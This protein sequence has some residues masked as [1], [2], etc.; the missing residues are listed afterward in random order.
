[1]SETTTEEEYRIV[2]V[3]KP[4]F[5]TRELIIPVSGSQV[6]SLFGRSQYK[7]NLEEMTQTFSHPKDGSTMNF[8]PA[9]SEEFLPIIAYKFEERAK[10]EIFDPSRLQLGWIL[11]AKE[12]VYI[13]ALD[14]Q[15][16]PIINEKDLES[17]IIADNKVN[18][19]YFFGDASYVPYDSFEQGEQD[20]DTFSRG[21]LARAFENTRDGV[22][23]N[24]K[25]ISSKE[26]YP[27]G[28]DV[29]GFDPVDE[30]IL[31]IATLGSYVGNRLSV[32]GY[33]WSGSY[34]YGYAFGVFDSTEGAAQK[35]GGKK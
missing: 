15:G 9:T 17:F 11:R 35:N 14:E 27:N 34:G 26:H 16:N 33:G 30:P 18:N 4:E 2:K 6:F 21:G 22:A 13:N 19:I 8:K 31:R 12:G 23:K 1:M 29:L 28:V 20:S 24:L 10:H 32:E 25:E 7:N 3:S 5:E